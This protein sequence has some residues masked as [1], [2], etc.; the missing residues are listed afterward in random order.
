[1]CVMSNAGGSKKKQKESASE[2][3]ASIES[4]GD[5][6][7]ATLI[8]DDSEKQESS[9]AEEVGLEQWL[10]EMGLEQYYAVFVE[11]GFDDLSFVLG[12]IRDEDLKAMGVDKIGHR[13]KILRLAGS[14]DHK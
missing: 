11:N 8:E 9:G 1:M 12:T 14:P 5:F 13:R 2:K 7:E 6:V 3:R 10:T 4:D